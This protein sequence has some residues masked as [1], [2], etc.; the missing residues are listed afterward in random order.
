M[1]ELGTTVSSGVMPKQA[2]QPGITE[3]SYLLKF[4]PESLDSFHTLG[5]PTSRPTT[6]PDSIQVRTSF[7]ADTRG[8]SN[9]YKRTS[10][11]PSSNP[12]SLVYLGSAGG[13]LPSGRQ[14]THVVCGAAPP[15]HGEGG[16]L[17]SGAGLE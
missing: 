5:C 6:S 2:G 16:G 17:W 13:A 4:K 14:D 1:A 11:A 9:V 3:Q 15:A 8:R 10:S 7:L 12:S